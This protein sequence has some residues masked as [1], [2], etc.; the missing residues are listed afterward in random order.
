MDKEK[1][2][3]IVGQTRL[4]SPIKAQL[5]ERDWADEEALQ[6]GIAEMVTM[7]AELVG[8]VG[9]NGA[10]Q[11]QEPKVLTAEQRE[12]AILDANKRWLMGQR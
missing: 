7:V 6:A 2:L 4:P 3:E 9:D 1:V 10:V 5:T 11:K 12:T 8:R